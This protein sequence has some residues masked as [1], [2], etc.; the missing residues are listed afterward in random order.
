MVVINK[1]Q[2]LRDIR[3]IRQLG[4][5]SH[6]GEVPVTVV[7]VQGTGAIAQHEKIRLTVVVVVS[8]Y[9]SRADPCSSLCQVAGLR[10][11]VSEFSSV[12][13]IES[14]GGARNF[15]QIEIAVAVVV[16]Q[17]N[18]AAELFQERIRKWPGAASW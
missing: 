13:A 14:L 5:G 18:S 7:V 17:H 6:I 12:V 15:K 11:N 8:G 10:G 3:I 1:S 16:E 4:P 9:C 2:G